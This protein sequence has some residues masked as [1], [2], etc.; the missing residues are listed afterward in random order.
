MLHTVGECC[1]VC[2]DDEHGLL[3]GL[4][5]EEEV[6]DLGGGGLV[7]VAGGFVG[8]DEG[9]FADEGSGDGGALALAA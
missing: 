9:R 1:A 6:G 4:E 2:D 8:E 7:E 3:V 5:L